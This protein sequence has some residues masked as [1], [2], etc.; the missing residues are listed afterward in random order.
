MI[1][2]SKNFYYHPGAVNLGI[3]RY[4]RIKWALNVMGFHIWRKQVDWKRARGGEDEEG[5]FL[6]LNDLPS[7][8]LSSY[9]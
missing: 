1:K 5:E 9:A 6:F 2:R 7:L 3:P 8:S 4:F